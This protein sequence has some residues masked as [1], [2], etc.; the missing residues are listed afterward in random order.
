MIYSHR[1]AA[2]PPSQQSVGRY[3]RRRRQRLSEPGYGAT[4]KS[5][6]GPGRTI[7]GPVDPAQDQVESPAQQEPLL[8]EPLSHDLEG[9]LPDEASYL[10]SR[11]R[12]GLRTLRWMMG[13]KRDAGSGDSSDE[14]HGEDEEPGRGRGMTRTAAIVASR[15]DRHAG[16]SATRLASEGSRSQPLSPSPAPCAADS[17]MDQN[18]TLPSDHTV[19]AKP[20][21][22]SAL[23]A[24]WRS[25]TTSGRDTRA[26]SR[27]RQASRPSGPSTIVL[28]AAGILFTTQ[29]FPRA[30]SDASQPATLLGM[31]LPADAA[32][33]MWLLS[34]PSL[35]TSDETLERVVGRISAWFCTLLYTTS[36]LPQIYVNLTRR[37]VKGLSIM[38]F[39]SAFMGN[40][41]YSASVLLN[42]QASGSGS[43]AYLLESLPF[44]LGSG[45]TLI[46]DIIIVAQ[47]I[48]WR[49]NEPRPIAYVQKPSRP[50]TSRRD[51]STAPL[52]RGGSTSRPALSPEREHRYARHRSRSIRRSLSRRSTSLHRS[53]SRPP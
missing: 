29:A 45:G 37:S 22:A 1:S 4:S 24:A 7:P 21:S 28:L 3:S 18:Q 46:F 47:W 38:L 43:R 2:S 15:H 25:R 5:R 40:S 34:S 33:P 36:R 51:S 12:A 6:T 27:R 19:I 16:Q 49:G 20:K 44:L 17:Q 53:S 8:E 39:L 30:P 9:A 31:T 41:L 14:E 50:W 11:P 23:P 32:R 13:R 35:D 10:L 52:T 48:A 42:P 26:R